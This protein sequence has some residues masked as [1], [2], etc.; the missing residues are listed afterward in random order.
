MF[1]LQRRKFH[2]GMNTNNLNEMHLSGH[3]KNSKLILP[4]V[5]GSLPVYIFQ[6]LYKDMD[7]F[8]QQKDIQFMVSALK[9][10]IWSQNCWIDWNS[11]VL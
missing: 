9:R 8:G 2:V 1:G 7:A 10:P 3:R 11:A 5:T 6:D 4:Q